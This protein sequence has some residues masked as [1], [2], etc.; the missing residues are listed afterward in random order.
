MPDPPR[1]RVDHHYPSTVPGRPRVST[2]QLEPR[3]RT[4]RIPLDHFRRSLGQ[5]SLG[6]TATVPDG[7]Q[8]PTQQADG[9]HY[10]RWRPERRH[11]LFLALQ[12][13][14][15]R[16]LERQHH[17]ALLVLAA[18]DVDGLQAAREPH[19]VQGGEGLALV[20]RPTRDLCYRS[21]EELL[22]SDRLFFLA[23]VPASTPGPLKVF[24]SAAVFFCLDS[25]S[26]HCYLGAVNALSPAAFARQGRSR[27]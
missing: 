4:D 8:Q 6:R 13:G 21:D 1:T 10:H 11:L 5:R 2:A 18:V 27:S 17:H 19:H 22:A 7:A 26:Y 15:V 14:Q 25:G 23:H 20:E 24:P 12:D 3:P 9:C 16:Q